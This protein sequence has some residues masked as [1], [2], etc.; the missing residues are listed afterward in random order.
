MQY[1]LV[2][3]LNGGVNMKY[4]FK[5][6]IIGLILTFTVLIS[7][8]G[9]ST[10][11]TT[12]IDN[13]LLK[14]DFYTSV[15]KDWL[16]VN[17]L[18]EGQP[19]INNFTETDDRITEY[20]SKVFENLL[21]RKN[22]FTQNSTERKMINFYESFVNSEDRNKNG[23][24]SLNAYIE[25]I[26]KVKTIDDLNTLLKD[27]DFSSFNGL[28]NFSVM[29]DFQGDVDK[30][31]LY[32]SPPAEI[33]LL[34]I[35]P[36]D[37]AKDEETKKAM[38]KQQ[39]ELSKLTKD[40]YTSILK[41]TGNSSEDSNKKVDNIINLDKMLSNFKADIT[42][43][44][45]IYTLKT[46]DESYPN[47][48]IPS[49]MKTLGYDKASRIIVTMPNYLENLN[50]IYVNENIDLIKDYLEISLIQSL[51][52]FLPD[53]FID[54]N[55]EYMNKVL[56]SV[57]GL[58]ASTESQLQLKPSNEDLALTNLNLIF[59]DAISNLFIKDYFTTK[60]KLQ[61]EI[62]TKEIVNEYRKTLSN[63]DVLDNQ[64]KKNAIKKLDNLK[65]EMSYDTIKTDY[66]D[67]KFVSHE[68]G[69]SSLK[70][71]V[72]YLNFQREISISSLNKKSNSIVWSLIGP[73]TVNAMYMGPSNTM[74]YPA[75]ILLPPFFDPTRDKE[76]NLASLGFV[77]AHEISHAFDMTGSQYDE[78]GK[79]N[80][81]WS[82]KD[83]DSFNK[84]TDKIKNF[85][86]KIE[87]V[88]GHFINGELT[89]NE[90]IADIGA[91]SAVL[92]ILDDMENPD[93]KK[94]FESY[95]KL[96]R[97]NSTNEKFISDLSMDSH[98]PNKW[99]VNAV[100]QQ[101]E[102]FYKAYNIKSGD[103]MYI[104]PKNRLSLW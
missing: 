35:M 86:S 45:N 98:S 8:T 79:L 84:K 63:T 66:D 20:T 75:G 65:I 18:K 24:N 19:S 36:Q 95:A 73:L 5:K 33:A 30:N 10:K 76:E 60:D 92:N 12:S 38:D 81:W 99:R 37:E 70:N 9:F 96:W 49:I 29:Q 42:S 15:N 101:F 68:N 85:Y 69:G 100:V 90:N 11:E 4:N 80:N 59:S 3:K 103:K 56:S 83:R 97:G 93:Y 32:I 62:L 25:K 34:A 48:N 23:L 77:I 64:T 82:D 50:S 67:L 28:F 94:F 6:K 47:L 21:K 7:T 102:E 22:T 44:Y 43:T 104:E 54:L 52:S 40:Y 53:D 2:Y 72:N 87:Q 1:M 41:L 55:Y 58:D 71:Y 39:E 13:S 78:N 57:P 89:L 31:A 17:K 91:M 14:N 61:V 27:P 26:H 88:P 51:N 46:L 16:S 74:H